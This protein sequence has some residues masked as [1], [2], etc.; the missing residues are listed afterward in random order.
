MPFQVKFTIEFSGRRNILGTLPTAEGYLLGFN[1]M[2]GQY[3]VRDCSS[4]VSKMGP[5][6]LSILG[7]VPH[8]CLDKPQLHHYSLVVTEDES[9]DKEDSVPKKNTRKT[10]GKSHNLK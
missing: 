1:N 5:V 8:Q 3:T 10:L 4:A 9:S 2:G 7:S 6:V